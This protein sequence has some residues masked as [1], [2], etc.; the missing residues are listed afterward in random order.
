[1]KQN[2]T[3]NS[4]LFWEIAT[5]IIRDRFVNKYFGKDISDVYWIADE[6]G[7]VL[8]VNDYFFSLDNM[9]NYLRYHYSSKMMF[10]HYQH[11]L[12]IE[13]K[14]SESKNQFDE[15]PINIKNYKKLKK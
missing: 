6:I 1:M 13:M 7:G 14:N 5:N 11:T 8:A 9:I 3:K 4:I 15:Y 10:E 12:D 2:Q